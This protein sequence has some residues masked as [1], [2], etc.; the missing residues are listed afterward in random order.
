MTFFGTAD[1]RMGNPPSV[2]ATQ[3]APARTAGGVSKKDQS[4][5]E[6]DDRPKLKIV[7][8]YDYLDEGGT[9]LFQVVRYE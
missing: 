5:P 9:L 7:A 8:T 6:L 2:P 4:L 3:S 1:F